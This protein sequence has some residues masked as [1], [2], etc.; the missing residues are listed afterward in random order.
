LQANLIATAALLLWGPLCLFVYTRTTVVRATA[1]TMFG[2]LLLLPNHAFLKL[3]AIPPLTK[4]VIPGIVAVL[5]ILLVARVRPSSPFRGRGI[6]FVVL[7]VGAVGTG[8][9]NGDS[10][11]FGLRRLPGIG[12]YDSYYRI[13]GSTLS[14][15]LPFWAGRLATRDA[16]AAREAMAMLALALVLYA[17]LIL[18]EIRLA[19]FLHRAVYGVHAFENF[20][21]ARRGGGFRPNVFLNHG[22]P[23]AVLV[24]AAVM[25]A[26][27]LARLRKP[28]GPI[29]SSRLVLGGLLVLQVLCKSFGG[30]IFGVVGAAVVF[31]ASLRIQHRFAALLVSLV[32]GYPLL[33]ANDLVPD[34][35]LLEYIE[36]ISSSD[37]AASLEYR[38]V[39]EEALVVRAMERPLFGWGTWGRAEIY[40][41]VSGRNLSVRDGAWIIILGDQGFVGFAGTFGLLIGPVLMAWRRRRWARSL[42][43]Q[44]TLAALS[45]IVAFYT[46]DLLPNG[47][48]NSLPFFLAGMLDAL[49]DR[50]RPR[51]RPD[52]S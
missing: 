49:V 15:L 2:G 41:L 26:A 42:E 34:E 51:R 27:L 47:L 20:S 39:N 9:T 45:V 23:L 7:A 6:W 37:R 31:F 14:L 19:P 5:G 8:L 18:L 13:V 36:Q 22:L 35:M 24:S 1:F 46:L 44:H 30:L 29:R 33:R 50:L 10:L 48:F 43:E 38:F 17:P 21:M 4:D 28:V 3:P 12:L 16:K 32:I 25:S 40:D 52:A 11:S